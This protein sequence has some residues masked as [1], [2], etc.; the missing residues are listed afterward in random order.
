MLFRGG[1]AL[2]MVAGLLM[3]HGEPHLIAGTALAV[4]AAS[5]CSR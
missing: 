4:A 1:G 3:I 5:A 2:D